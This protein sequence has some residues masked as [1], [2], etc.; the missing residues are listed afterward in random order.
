MAKI[1]SSLLQ[2]VR[3]PQRLS[4][5]EIIKLYTDLRN[6]DSSA[7]QKLIEHHLRIGLKIAKAFSTRHPG[8]TS[9]FISEMTLG[10]S[11]GV[12]RLQE[13]AIDHH[14]EPNPTGFLIR[15]MKGYMR[16]FFFKDRLLAITQESLTHKKGKVAVVYMSDFHQ[17][18][19]DP[20]TLLELRDM[21]SRINFS[22]QERQVIAGRLACDTDSEIS[23]RMGVTRARVQQIRA[24]VAERLMELL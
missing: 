7:G 13:G 10:L 5:A 23:V 24:G 18:G 8:R 17:Y 12:R 14:K 9:D 2:E 6:G 19:S 21:M 4:S 16:R 1:K 3:L 15:T 11:V 22:K 20:E